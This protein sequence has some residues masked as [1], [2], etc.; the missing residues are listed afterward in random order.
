VDS[1][2]DTGIAAAELA[3]ARPRPVQTPWGPFSLF[4]VD[5][6][7]LCVQSFCPHLGGP[8]FE[9]TVWGRYVTCPWHGWSF[10]LESGARVDFEGR[11]IPSGKA[12]ATCQVELSPNGTLVLRAPRREA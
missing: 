4:A 10:A 5:G 11:P 6:R 7:V 2:F 9:G 8:L 3:G 12:L 1:A